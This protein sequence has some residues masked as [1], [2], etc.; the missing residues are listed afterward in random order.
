MKAYEDIEQL[1]YFLNDFEARQVTRRIRYE[2]RTVHEI[3][4]TIALIGRKKK[5]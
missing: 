1:N 4:T 3:S 2:N 5:Y